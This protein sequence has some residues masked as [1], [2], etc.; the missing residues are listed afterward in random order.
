MQLK[1][2]SL[3]EYSSVVKVREIFESEIPSPIYRKLRGYAFDPALSMQIETSAINSAI[4]KVRWEKL[5]PGPTGEYIEVI[6]IDPASGLF[7]DPVDLDDKYILAQDGLPMSESSPKFHQQ[8]VYAVAM[9][10]IENFEKALGRIVLWSGR[11]NEVAIEDKETF[12]RQLRIYPHSLREANAYYSPTKKALLFGYFPAPTQDV[13]EHMP[14]GMVFTCLSQ[15]II[16]HE[17]THA[18][19]DG[20]HRRFIE[21]TQP[22]ALAFHEAFADIVALFQHFSMPEVLYH[23]IAKTKGDLTSQSLLG[24]LAQEFGKAIGHYGALRSAIGHENP[25]TKKWEL[26]V[27]DPNDYNTVFE[28]HA[29]GSIL[30]S[31]IFEAFITI[32]N[33][34]VKDLFQIATGGSSILP[35][36][37][38]H[39]TLVKML[40]NEASKA[41]SH[42]LTICIRALDYCPPVDIN[43]GDYL[44]AIITADCDLVP[45]D[46]MEYRIAFVDAFKRRGIIP[47]GIK[48]LSIDSLKYPI[49]KAGDIIR[50]ITIISDFLRDYQN[51]ISYLKD[52]NEIYTLTKLYRQELHKMFAEKLEDSKEFSDLTG[53]LFRQSDVDRYELNS[54]IYGIPSFEIHSL[55][56]ARRVGPDGDALNQVI[57]S[58][59]QK[60]EVSYEEW[61]AY[62]DEKNLKITN[63]DPNETI[64]FRGGST[65]IIDLDKQALR[66]C[67]NKPMVDPD[68]LKEQINYQKN[69]E[70]ASLYATYFSN[71][72]SQNNPEPLALL[73][74]F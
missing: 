54:G 4:F 63:L 45:D 59:T 72:L 58:I 32:Y 73:H 30:V 53:L 57:I 25:E 69:F 24:E 49:V 48:T 18:L 62:I 61:I 20:I 16:S 3:S 13:T 21:P 17:T 70:S 66:Y 52:R 46:D 22:D 10:T 31:A 15:D 74:R 38:L 71:A 36:G 2:K 28:P 56:K 5:S 43:F 1:G 23:Q 26:S 29:R 51:V 55:R 8:M 39:P 65:L 37:E 41:A 34:R 68:R 35:E 67:I 12:V 9:R 6:D 42:V 19:L 60:R 11:Y 64:T 47:K 50:K 40:A 27:P 7:Y 14:G 33:L 44:R